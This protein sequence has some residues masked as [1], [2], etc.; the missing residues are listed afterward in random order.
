[1]SIYFWFQLLVLIIILF[2]GARKGSIFLGLVSGIGLIVLVFGPKPWLG[3]AFGTAPI[4]VIMTIMAVVA[5][6]A[7]LQA[8]GGLEC[9]L[10]VAEKVLRS[11]PKL[12][13][14]LAPFC[15]FI[16]TMLAGTGH[17]VYTLFPIVYDVAIKRGVRP[18][19]PMAAT[20]VCAQIGICSSP[21]SVA[22]VTTV[23]FLEGHA[24]AN[25]SE[26]NMLNLLSLSIPSGIIGVLAV[27]LFS[28]FRG[29]DLDKDPDF[30]ARIAD[31]EAKKYIYGEGTTLLGKK[32]PGKHWAALWVFL[33]TVLL[34]AI[35]GGFSELRPTYNGKA[36]SM[37]YVIQMFMLAAAS[38]IVM[39]TKTDP[40]AISQAA[41]FRSGMVA[42]VSVFGVAWMSNA[43]FSY[44]L[45]EL[46][47][48]LVEYVKAYPWA[49][50][51]VLW[52][53]SF[54]LNSQ[55]AAIATIVPV[56]LAVG[57]PPGIVAGM[58][59]ACYAYYILP[60][61][62]SDLAAIEFD[63][64]GTTHIGKF[65]INH[66]FILP[67]LIGVWTATIIGFCLAHLYGWV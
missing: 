6:G 55:G 54:L 56:A 50:A 62:P 22:V 21:V 3:V 51:I 35:M 30:Q 7:T 45:V 15:S 43:M 24:L 61:Y 40:K 47:A 66:S 67:G 39:I 19:R 42:A 48:V 13:T 38:I 10:Q 17:T 25:G 57:T 53:V 29:K 2:I 20:S 16:L 5:A 9:L 41:V 37:T 34:V 18:E 63:R 27:A 58:F 46:K 23:A 64:S 52:L 28:N 60:V 1:M 8:S 49:Y 44:H 4:D 31:P 12:V 26:I 65:V 33:I 11:H 36:I 59:T 32:L 14:F